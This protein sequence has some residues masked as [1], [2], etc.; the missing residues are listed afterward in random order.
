M[1]KF[2]VDINAFNQ[3]LE[4]EIPELHTTP[5]VSQTAL[6]YA[7]L[8]GI[9]EFELVNHVDSRRAQVLVLLA[10]AP[11]LEHVAK[12]CATLAKIRSSA[13][14]SLGNRVPIVLLLDEDDDN[15]QS[16]G[17]ARYKKEMKLYGKLD[18]D[19]LEAS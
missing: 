8:H 2:L 16:S 1:Q 13:F 17:R 18:Y 15:T 10:N 3:C 4:T 11:Q 6:W 14:Y 9:S 5:M 7:Q 19:A 12:Q